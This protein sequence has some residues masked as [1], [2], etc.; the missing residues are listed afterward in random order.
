MTLLAMA[1]G[2]APNDDEAEGKLGLEAAHKSRRETEKG[3]DRVLGEHAQEN[4][5]RLSERAPQVLGLD[6]DAECSNPLILP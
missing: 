5:L 2:A 1:P 3:H 4:T 6:D